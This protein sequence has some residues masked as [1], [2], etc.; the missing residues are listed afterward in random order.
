VEEATKRCGS[1]HRDLPHSAFNK[2][3]A[4]RDGLMA[5]CRECDSAYKKRWHQDNLDREHQK[6]RDRYQN[7]DEYRAAINT[8]SLARY[9]SD[10]DA[11]NAAQRAR[12]AAN[13]EAQRAKDR[14][15]RTANKERVREWKRRYYE[16]HGDRVRAYE[17]EQYR[18][19][20]SKKRQAALEW[21]RKN[22][23]LARLR[24][25]RRKARK[26]ALTIGEI[27]P[28]LLAGKLAYW[29]WC[30]WMCGEEPAA[31]DHV[32]PLSRGGAHMLA[33]LRPACVR[34]N[35]SKGARWPL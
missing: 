12:R 20:P 13:P 5:K 28:V 8:R 23:E 1:C 2:R 7:D 27:T 11:W 32:K 4:S 18:N 14:A 26:L 15:Y 25:N 35:A 6:A 9:R 19:D 29:G 34:C 3:R 10:P 22:P 21:Q 31:W 30:C 17:A 24:N 33:N 16:R